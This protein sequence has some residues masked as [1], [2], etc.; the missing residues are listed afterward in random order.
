MNQCNAAMNQCIEEI[1]EANKLQKPAKMK[2]E[3]LQSE[4]KNSKNEMND[5]FDKISILS[6]KKQAAEQITISQTR[7]EEC[8]SQLRDISRKNISTS[9]C[10]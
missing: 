10:R 5:T 2:F 9:T 8:Q 6:F 1:N 7:N 4:A 3:A